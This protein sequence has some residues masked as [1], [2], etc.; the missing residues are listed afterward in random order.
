MDRPLISVI[1]TTYNYAHTVGTAIDSALAQ[2]YPNLEVVVVDN[3]STDATPEL[4]R[5]YRSDPRVRY[6]RN[7]ANIGMVPNHNKG[8]YETRGAYVL[9]L[10]ADDFLLPGHLTT[11]YGYLQAHPEV[12]V[13]YAS[14]YFVDRAGRY[15]GVRQMTGQPLVPYVGGRDELPNL[16]TLN[17]YMCFPTMLM[18]RELFDRFGPLDE[19]I[20]AADFE[21]VLRWAAEGVRFAYVPEATCAVRLHSDQ[22]SSPENYVAGGDDIREYIYLLEKYLEPYASRYHGFE[23]SVS[24]Q[25]WTRYRLATDG[26]ELDDGEAISARLT[27]FD[28]ILAGISAQNAA[29]RPPLEPTFI[30]LGSRDIS[31]MERTFRSLVAQTYRGWKAVVIEA[32]SYSFAALAAAIDPEGRISTHHP[33]VDGNDGVALNAA[34]LVAPGN[35]FFPIR[36]GNEFPPDHLERVISTFERSEFQVSRCGARLEVDGVGP[37]AIYDAYL[38]P[39]QHRL[40]WSAPFGPLETLAFT[41]TGL[42]GLMFNESL[43]A[44]TEWEM[45]LRMAMRGVIATVDS[46]ATV[47]ARAGTTATFDRC[48]DLPRIARALYNVFRNEDALVVAEREQYLQQLEG[49]VDLGVELGKTAD[50]IVRLEAA[51]SGR[52]IVAADS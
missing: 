30:V 27:A 1:V 45:F 9:F 38:A 35:V 47:H 25:M 52:A 33:I 36:A 46:V 24:R 44:Y 23:T 22:Q 17:C 3:A 19:S 12:D 43:P 15:I 5:R 21:L 18:K 6:S 10:S 4:M 20:K 26:G 42:N 49:A 39:G 29:A 50:G 7:P 31:L 11:L 2:D 37:G 8:L 51:A 48:A 28:G 41:R 34:M 13:F 40:L 32:I 16:I 14:S